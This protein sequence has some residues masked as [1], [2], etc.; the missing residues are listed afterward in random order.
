MLHYTVL[1]YLH[2]RV[3]DVQLLLHFTLNSKKN[4]RLRHD[5]KAPISA[6]FN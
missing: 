5:R 6:I 3:C 1:I 2:L 4:K